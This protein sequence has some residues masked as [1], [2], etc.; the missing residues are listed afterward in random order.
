MN[1]L[2]ED[3]AP[4]L[5]DNDDDNNNNNDMV[6]ATRIPTYHVPTMSSTFASQ[7]PMPVQ[8]RFSAQPAHSGGGGGGAAASMHQ[9]AHRA[10]SVSAPTPHTQLPQSAGSAKNGL[11]AAAGDAVDAVPLPAIY[12]GG[13]IQ[14][15]VDA[16]VCV[17]CVR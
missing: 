14:D 9:L 2:F 5:D 13:A 16:C 11:F 4:G 15:V 8:A 10:F 12:T 6:A 7:A 17:R 1:N 3:W